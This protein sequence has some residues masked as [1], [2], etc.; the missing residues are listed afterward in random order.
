MDLHG[1]AWICMDLLYNRSARVLF[2]AG[3]W[4]HVDLSYNN[5]GAGAALVMGS[6]A[7]KLAEVRAHFFA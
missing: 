3:H 4:R 2:A 6:L 5:V 1:F 7:K